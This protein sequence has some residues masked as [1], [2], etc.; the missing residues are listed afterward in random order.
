MAGRMS[1]DVKLSGDERM[2]CHAYRASG[3]ILSIYDCVGVH[4]TI[5]QLHEKTV[6]PEDV[7][8]AR[9]LLVAV[10]EYVA[11]CQRLCPE[12]SEDNETVVVASQ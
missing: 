4:L 9:K 10:V 8:A 2:V 6:T 7:R 5:T 1:V 12:S 11:E 3:P